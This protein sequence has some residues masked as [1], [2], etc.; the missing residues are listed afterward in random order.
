MKMIITMKKKKKRR[1]KVNAMMRLA[2]TVTVSSTTIE[3]VIMDADVNIIMSLTLIT[4]MWLRIVLFIDLHYLQ[5][6]THTVV[7]CFANFQHVWWQ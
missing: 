2:L 7:E 6:V 5:Q 4:K 3:K 1:R